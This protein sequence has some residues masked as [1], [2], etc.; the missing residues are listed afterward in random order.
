MVRLLAL[1]AILP[2]LA[3]GQSC[4]HPFMPL[5]V[6]ATWVYRLSSGADHL[7]MTVKVESARKDRDGEVADLLTRVTDKNDRVIA[8]VLRPYRCASDGIHS[9]PP[10]G[11][12]RGPDGQKVEVKVLERRGVTLPPPDA[13]HAGTAFHE[14]FTLEIK[15]G[16]DPAARIA[17]DAELQV[18]GI[19][20]LTVEAGTFEAVHV[21][22]EESVLLPA[23][24]K[25]MKQKSETWYGK[26]VGMIRTRS[27]EGS[28]EL[29]KFTK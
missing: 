3:R 29:V 17:R 11:G 16:S 15:A 28:F 26:G 12:A 9:D 1:L 20:P 22:G 2:S 10:M 27:N 4:P 8:E 14:G 13:L 24:T 21:V 5:K 19:E 23:T 6:G 18:V 7:T 25:P